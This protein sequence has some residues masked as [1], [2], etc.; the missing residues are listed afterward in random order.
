MLTVAW[1]EYTSVAIRGY[2]V[3]KL[4]TKAVARLT[5]AEPWLSCGEGG[6]EHLQREDALLA[7]VAEGL[8]ES[9]GH[10]GVAS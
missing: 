10:A 4:L 2:G 7:H 3:Y 1:L 8:S 9:A 5:L 6:T